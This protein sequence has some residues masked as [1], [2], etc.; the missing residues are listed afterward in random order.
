MLV[1]T[2]IREGEWRYEERHPREAE[3][4]EREVQ[5]EYDAMDVEVGDHLDS[6]RKRYSR[7][8]AAHRPTNT[9][10]RQYQGSSSRVVLVWWS[11]RQVPTPCSEEEYRQRDADEAQHSV[12]HIDR[13]R[14][15]ETAKCGE[16][17]SVNLSVCL[18]I[19]PMSE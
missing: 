1:S 10:R 14:A 17:L 13:E 8:N 3:D 11:Q 4:G 5:L 2:E 7:T 15:R 12:I 9:R 6:K 18:L 19:G 16:Y